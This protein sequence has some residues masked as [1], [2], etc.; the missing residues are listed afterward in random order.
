MGGGAGGLKGRLSGLAKGAGAV[1]AGGIF[2]GP[3]G[4]IGGAIGLKVGGPAGAAV[5]AAI[6]AQV[7]MVRQSIGELADFSAQLALQRKALGLVI[8]DTEKFAKSQNAIGLRWAIYK[9]SEIP[10]ELIIKKGKELQIGTMQRP[11]LARALYFTSE[12]GDEIMSKLYNKKLQENIHN[13]LDRGE[14]TISV[15]A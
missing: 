4:A 15:S 1:A 9:H 10:Y 14:G 7:G 11:K 6:G 5:G 2:G 3:E 13:E 8:G 12:I